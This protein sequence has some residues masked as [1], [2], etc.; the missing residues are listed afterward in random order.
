MWKLPPQ[1]AL[2]QVGVNLWRVDHDYTR[3]LA[4]L[5]CDVTIPKGFLTDKATIP[6]WA[7]SRIAPDDLLAG[8]VVHDFL[9]RVREV[10]GKTV[11]RKMADLVFHDVM[12]QDRVKGNKLSTA[13]RFVRIL[14]W[15]SWR[16]PNM[17][18]PEKHAV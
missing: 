14:G 8:P 7:W 10:G 13:Y 3:F 2:T 16:W 11:S 9:Y 12:K 5:G 6:H 18:N 1:P 17:L 15:I 4:R